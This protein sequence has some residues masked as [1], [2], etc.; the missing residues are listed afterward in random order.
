VLRPNDSARGYYRLVD[1]KE[2]RMFVIR[3]TG[4]LSLRGVAVLQSNVLL[5]PPGGF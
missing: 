5:A 4:V 3:E 1:F 2:N